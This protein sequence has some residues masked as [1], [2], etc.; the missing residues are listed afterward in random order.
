[1][2]LVL[3][4]VDGGNRPGSTL[5]FVY[6]ALNLPML[7]RDLAAIIRQFPA[8]RNILAR[9]LEPLSAP[10]ETPE[11]VP[12]AIPDRSRDGVEIR[13][14]D[15]AV[16]TGGHE[17]LSD[18]GFTIGAGEHVAVVGRSGAGKST[19][20]GL[21]LGW[22]AP[23]AGTVRADG[24]A[25]AGERLVDLR[26]HTA[27]VDPSVHLWNRSLFDN[28]R[29]GDPSRLITS[30]GSVIDTAELTDVLEKLPAGLQSSLGE[31][32]GL[33]SGGEGQRV[34]FGRA[35]LREPVRL[36][37]LD[38]PF[39]GL[40]R[41]TRH[42]LLARARDVWSDAT[43]I[44]VT[45][46]IEDTLSFERVIVLDAGRI[47]EEGQPSV[48]RNQADS[49]YAALLAAERSVKADLWSAGRWRRWHIRDGSI[50]EEDTALVEDQWTLQQHWRGQ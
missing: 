29:Y 13:F 19:L 4:F 36:A 11:A 14:E 31:G 38:E 24:D 37:I 44:C 27:W 12:A 9:I 28:L 49:A 6:W 47:V 1:V 50:A 42:E 17:I 8:Y 43:L 40:D 2:W 16:R 22:H 35:L 21:L 3:A 48:L 33:T 20:V 10:A 5:L 34:R 15:V 7:G 30:I 25:L 18:I 32:G 26:R 45:H 23:T 41:G 39:R 46:D